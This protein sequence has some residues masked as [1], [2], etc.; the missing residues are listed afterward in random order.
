MI[1][2]ISPVYES[3]FILPQ[4]ALDSSMACRVF[5]GLI[6]GHIMD[7][8]DAASKATASCVFR[9]RPD[10]IDHEFDLDDI[11]ASPNTPVVVIPRTES[12]HL[13]ENVDG[14]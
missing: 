14:W 11:H 5:R 10:D 6:I 12:S 7:I 1:A 8:D 4:V 3:M 9:R 2:S 13:R